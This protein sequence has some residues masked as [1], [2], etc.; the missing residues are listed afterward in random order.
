MQYGP[1]A[2]LLIAICFHTLLL[3][4]NSSIYQLLS[5]INITINHYWFIS[6]ITYLQYCIIYI[7]PYII[8]T[9]IQWWNHAILHIHNNDGIHHWPYAHCPYSNCHTTTCHTVTLSLCNVVIR[10]QFYETTLHL[11]I[12]FP[13]Y[14][15]CMYESLI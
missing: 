11:I 5:Y 1:H 13:I 12:S 3:S 2:S 15:Y 14:T 10:P 6:I 8:I 7:L 4:I 9:I